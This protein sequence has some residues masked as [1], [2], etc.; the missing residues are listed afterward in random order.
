MDLEEGYRVIVLSDGY[1]DQIAGEDIQKLKSSGL[2]KYI[3]ESLHMTVK[4]QGEYLESMFKK[5]KG[6][7][8]QMDDTLLAIIEF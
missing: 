8:Q 5:Y 2:Q 3:K 6:R 4:E 7:H 1:T